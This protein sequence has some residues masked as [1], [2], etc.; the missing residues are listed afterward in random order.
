MRFTRHV[1]GG[2]LFAQ[3]TENQAMEGISLHGEQ[4][5][6]VDS[7]TAAQGNPPE[8]TGEPGEFTGRRTDHQTSR[9]IAKTSQFKD[10][11]GRIKKG[12]GVTATD[13]NFLIFPG[14]CTA[15][16]STINGL[17]RVD[18]PLSLRLLDGPILPPVGPSP[19]ENLTVTCLLH[20]SVQLWHQSSPGWYAA[21]AARQ[22]VIRYR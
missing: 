21:P 10:N 3:L 5:A 8:V 16:G 11:S 17:D 12:V 18:S 4:P 19:Q 7:T 15:A 2:S 9:G 20:C 1:Q 13:L 6:K 22:R 14:H